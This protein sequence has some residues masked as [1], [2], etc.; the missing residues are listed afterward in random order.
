MNLLMVGSGKGVWEIRGLQ[1]GGALG[2]RLREY[3]TPDDFAWADVVILVK[4]A[5]LAYATRVHAL[6]KPLIWDPVDAWSQ[7]GQ[8]HY[9]EREARAWLQ[10]EIAQRRPT[11]TMGATQAMTDA[12]GPG[13]VYL[14]HHHRVGLQA[15][16][17]RPEIQVVAYDGRPDYLGQWRGVLERL[18]A[19]RRWRFAINPPD[20]SEAD[21]FVA[22]RDSAWDGYMPRAW[23]SG[24]KVVNAIA[25]GRPILSQEMASAR[26]IRP[27]GH[28]CI[29]TVAE[30]EAALDAWRDYDRR[31][32]VAEWCAAEAP[33]HIV[34]AV[35]AY[36]RGVLEEV[37][38]PA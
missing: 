11:R 13:G 9:T 4:R 35:A 24:V 38:C 29:E 22:L 14:P 10:A 16:A 32:A 28:T 30:L 31:L 37:L 19:A 17:P 34:T 2:A 5:A 7:P 27:L 23:K 20:L 3:P 25:A 26:E 36:Y 12:I 21:L 6:G 18:C 33:K 15:R 8:N 1:L